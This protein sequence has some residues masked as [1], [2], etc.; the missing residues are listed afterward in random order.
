MTRLL[1]CR[2]QWKLPDPGIASRA[3]ASAQ[4]VARDFTLIGVEAEILG[5]FDLW[6]VYLCGRWAA[7]AESDWF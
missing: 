4:N 1:W 2:W 3:R 7:A 5:G 6:G